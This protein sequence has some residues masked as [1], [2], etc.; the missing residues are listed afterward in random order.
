MAQIPGICHTNTSVPLNVIKFVGTEHR[1]VVLISYTVLS[2]ALV[3]K[4]LRQN[5]TDLPRK[6]N[7]LQKFQNENVD[8][9]FWSAKADRKIL[10]HFLNHTADIYM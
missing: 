9:R 7:T 8:R 6:G 5:F 1:T 2:A 3:S 4:I 10:R